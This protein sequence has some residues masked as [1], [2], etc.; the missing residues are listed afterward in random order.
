MKTRAFLIGFVV[1]L[2]W[3]APSPNQTQARMP[4][5]EANKTVS[6]AATTQPTYFSK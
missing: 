6:I 3:M 1:L 4:K 2:F 5:R